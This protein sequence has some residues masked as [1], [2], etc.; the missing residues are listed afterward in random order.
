MLN[1]NGNYSFVDVEMTLRFYG[2]ENGYLVVFE[3][4]CEHGSSAKGGI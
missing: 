4:K 3:G 2:F 1:T